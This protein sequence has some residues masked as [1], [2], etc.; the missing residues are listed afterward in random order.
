MLIQNLD[1]RLIHLDAPLPSDQRYFVHHAEA[2]HS[3]RNLAHHRARN[4]NDAAAIG[5]DFFWLHP[6]PAYSI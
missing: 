4:L 5:S 6:A 3:L 1:L 2:V